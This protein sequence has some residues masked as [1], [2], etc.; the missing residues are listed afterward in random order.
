MDTSN[1]SKW[2]MWIVFAVAVILLCNMLNKKGLS[3]R[4]PPRKRVQLQ[5]IELSS[6]RAK[7]PELIQSESSNFSNAPFPS[8]T[9]P[10]LLNDNNTSPTPSA[11]P[12]PPPASPPPT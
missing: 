5:E 1:C 3:G 2:L 11:P 10:E 9:K 7:R 4:P 6:F 12:L 8:V